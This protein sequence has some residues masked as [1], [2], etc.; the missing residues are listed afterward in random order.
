MIDKVE[1]SKRFGKAYRTYDDASCIQ[2]RSAELLIADLMHELSGIQDLSILDVGAG[3]GCVTRLLDQKLQEIATDSWECSVRYTLNDISYEMLSLA[4]HKL[5]QAN[6][7]NADFKVG[8]MEEI[9]FCHHNIVVSNF[10]LQWANCL[11]S[12]IK[13][14]YDTS[15]IFAFSCLLDGTFS[16]WHELCAKFD[17]ET[18]VGKLERIKYPK[19]QELIDYI[20]QKGAKSV[21][22]RIETFETSFDCIRSFLRYLRRI[23]ASYNTSRVCLRDLRNLVRNRQFKPFSTKYRVFFAVLVK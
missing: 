12:T 7:I 2:K 17:P 16:E 14:L 9:E 8:D 6:I 19:H 18:G 13:K 4:K 23:G 5:K 10:A 11:Q 1:L 22:Y 3:T 15:D 21:R 20:N